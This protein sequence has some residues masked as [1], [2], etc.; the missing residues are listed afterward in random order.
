[1]EQNVAERSCEEEDYSL[2][3]ETEWIDP[4]ESN[5]ADVENI[6]RTMNATKISRT[7]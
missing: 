1:M 3:D 5:V 6:Y 7:S 2:R 4:H